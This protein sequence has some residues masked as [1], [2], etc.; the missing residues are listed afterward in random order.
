MAGA[1]KVGSHYGLMFMNIS[2]HLLC[3]LALMLYLL[4]EL[5]CK[6]GIL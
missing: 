6:R 1:V 3:L 4:I 2:S 5:L